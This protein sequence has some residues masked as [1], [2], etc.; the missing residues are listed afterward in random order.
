MEAGP[1]GP[2]T[3]GHGPPLRAGRGQQ[4]LECVEVL[5]RAL[6]AASVGL[7]LSSPG[8]DGFSDRRDLPVEARPVHAL[9]FDATSTK[10]A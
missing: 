1:G 2:G 4:P 7:G 3:R 6:R 8:A 5:E 10:P 9:G